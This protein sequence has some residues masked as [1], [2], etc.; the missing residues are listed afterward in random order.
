MESVQALLLY[1]PFTVMAL[2]IGQ[3]A[4]ATGA[5]PRVESSAL[6][7]DALSAEMFRIE[8]RRRA[9]DIVDPNGAAPTASVRQREYEPLHRMPVQRL[10][11]LRAQWQ[12]QKC[13]PNATRL[14]ESIAIPTGDARSV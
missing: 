3:P 14:A 9:D 7:C 2:A 1:L 12:R 4:S 8:K 11:E 6:T 13:G 10:S 5:Q